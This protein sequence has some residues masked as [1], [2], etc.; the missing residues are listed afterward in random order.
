MPLMDA[1]KMI[2]K[3]VTDFGTEVKNLGIKILEGYAD[4][5]SEYTERPGENLCPSG[6]LFQPRA[7]VATFED[8]T[9]IRYPIGDRSNL[10][11]RARELLG[12]GAICIDYEGEYWP[13]VPSTL[14]L[15]TRYATQP[16]G[17][18]TND[19]SKTVGVFNYQSDI[20]GTI[21]QP[22]AIESVPAI[23]V[24]T[25]IACLSGIVYGSGFCT[26]VRSLNIKARRFRGKG[27]IPGNTKKTYSRDIKMS[28]P[29]PTNCGAS[30]APNY[31]C[32]SYIG[33]TIKNLHLILPSS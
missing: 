26:G 12:N 29:N 25:A 14:I 11:T 18:F 4:K 27:L 33:E 19:G 1:T 30:N 28:S 6:N 23:L 16:L 9:K 8:G 3:Y 22:F 7:L 20:L 24:T 32:M 13:Y 15:N 17:G 10:V 21:V 31:Y 5:V 2:E